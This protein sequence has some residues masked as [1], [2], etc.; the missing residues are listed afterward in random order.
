MKSKYQFLNKPKITATFVD[1]DYLWIAFEGE[2]GES[3]LYKVSLYNPKL[4]YW[5][6]EVTADKINFLIDDATYVYLAIDDDTYI[7]EKIS[8][9]SPSSTYYYFTKPI[10]ITEGAIDLVDDTT[11][12]YFL[13]P[14]VISGTNAKICKFNKSTRAFVETIDLP[15]VN[16]AKKID[17]DYKGYLWV[18]SDLDTTPKITKV[19]Y[20]GTWQYSTTTLS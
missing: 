16:N 19:W 14:G 9:T 17:I 11:F 10:G 6:L 12:V 20:D 15:L 1:G 8:K 2:D 5:E 13:I 18:I 4:I 3:S 7:G